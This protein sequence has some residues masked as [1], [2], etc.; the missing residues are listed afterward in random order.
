MIHPFQHGKNPASVVKR[1]AMIV[2]SRGEIAE[3]LCAIGMPEL[4]AFLLIGERPALFD[5][6]MTFM[7]P[8]YI[9]GLKSRLGDEKRLCFNF[10]THSHFDHC[11]AG[12][13]LKR[14]IGHLQTGAHPLAADTFRKPGAV[15]L[16]RSL[17]EHFEKRNPDEDVSFD[18]L[19]VEIVLRDGME[20]DPGGGLDF[21]VIATPGHTRD[22]VCFYIRKF[23]ALITGEAA[24][25]Y[26]R[27]MTIHP[28]FLSSYRDYL[29]SLE[30]LAALEPEILMMGHYFT[31]TGA[32][33]KGYIAKS[34]ERTRAFR[35]RIEDCLHER[36]G[37]TEAVVQRIF[38]EDYRETGAIL[39]EERPYLINLQ[40]K[41]R[42]V[43]E[44]R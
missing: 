2:Q 8:R 21:R 17:S 9:E 16:I 41:V 6:G 26:D 7:G 11:G 22:S 39:Q 24:G 32:D 36:N 15:S 23:R 5:A 12:P 30:K 14:K 31:L 43:A 33:A 19:N 35:A 20:I 38:R 34:I 37:D 18:G 28:E 44:K 29:H 4:P 1:I 3:G 25:V 42:A 10:L 27:N 13:F 40:A